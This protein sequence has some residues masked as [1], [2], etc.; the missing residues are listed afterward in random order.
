MLEMLELLEVLEVPPHTRDRGQT[1]VASSKHE[2]GE[3][4]LVCRCTG[5]YRL[6]IA[7]ERDWATVAISS[8]LGK[9]A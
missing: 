1:A 4:Q 8:G 7:G 5:P 2:Y 3:L 9:R 6:A